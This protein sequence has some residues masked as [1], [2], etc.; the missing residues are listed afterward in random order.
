YVAS[1]AG[2]IGMTKVWARELGKDG[3][4][5][6]AVTPGFIETAMTE[7]I[8]DKVLEM[9][10]TRVPLRR[11]GS[12]ED[13]AATYCFLASDNAA[14]ITGQVLGVDGGTVT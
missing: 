5:V 14:Y 6:N 10:M 1:K 7:G 4:R 8:P 2:V 9:M 13:V 12:P 11:M 3:I